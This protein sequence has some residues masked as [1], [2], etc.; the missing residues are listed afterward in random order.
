MAK[1]PF[2]VLYAP[3]KTGGTAITRTLEAAGIVTHHVHTLRGDCLDEMV[4]EFRDDGKVPSLNVWRSKYLIAHPPVSEKP[5]RLITTIREPI[6]RAVSFHF[7][8]LRR[9]GATEQPTVADLSGLDTD[10]FDDELGTTLGIDVYAEPF[11][12]ERGWQLYT[13]PTA[14]VLVMR[15]ESLSV[16]PV[17][18][19]IG[20]PLGE[21]AVANVTADKARLGASYGRYL[22][23]ATIEREI[24]ERIYGSR[25]ARHFYT[26]EERAAFSRRWT[27]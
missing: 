12:A 10:W 6:A 3:P 11:D 21:M 24:V 27:G 7:H 18:D 23:T 5:W 13:G 20:V 1:R 9:T 22:E 17:A 25:F 2:A 8:R 19:F 15:Q 14:E 16:G 26:D 4:R